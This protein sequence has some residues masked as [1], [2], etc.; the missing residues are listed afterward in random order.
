MVFLDWK[1]CHADGSEQKSLLLQALLLIFVAFAAL[2]LIQT[3]AWA[4]ESLLNHEKKWKGDLDGMVGDIKS[5]SSSLT[6]KP[7]TSWTAPPSAVLPTR[8]CKSL[9]N[10]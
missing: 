4:A 10:G 8:G 7:S 2:I 6:V 9:G 5:A 3:G 1:S